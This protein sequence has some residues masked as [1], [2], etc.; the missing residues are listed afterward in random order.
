MASGRIAMRSLIGRCSNLAGLVG[1]EQVVVA[2]KTGGE[3]I[4][5]R[6]VEGFGVTALDDLAL[7]HQE[8]P[9]G[10][11]QRFFLVVG[12]ENRGQAQFAL[13]LADLFAQVFANPC[14]QRR[15]R[16][17]QQQQARTGH[18]RAGEGHA[19]TLAAGHLV[20]ITAGEVLEFHQ[21]QHFGTRLWL[22][23]ALTFCM[24]RPNATFCST[25]MLGNSA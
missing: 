20:R 1:V 25:V 21:L 3:Y 4:H 10:H 5:G 2:D 8:N 6:G 24:R 17:I 7:V 22:S 15:Q 12:H 14:I 18:Q 11:G 13:D 19:L 23:S 16:F 9:V